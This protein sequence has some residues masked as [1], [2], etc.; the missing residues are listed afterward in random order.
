[1]SKNESLTLNMIRSAEQSYLHFTQADLFSVV[2]SYKYKIMSLQGYL[3][4]M[5]TDPNI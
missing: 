2:T 3:L 5:H 4:V 1:M